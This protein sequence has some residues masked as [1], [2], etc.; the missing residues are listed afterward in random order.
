MLPSTCHSVDGSASRNG[1]KHKNY[2]CTAFIQI[3]FK[4]SLVGFKNGAGDTDLE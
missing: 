1:L 2:Y 4:F 3:D